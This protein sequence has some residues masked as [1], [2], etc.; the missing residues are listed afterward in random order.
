MPEIT[1]LPAQGCR[2]SRKILDYLEQHAIPFT[3]IDLESDE[4]QALAERYSLRASPGI[5]VDGQAI[6]PFDLLIQPQ[7]RVNQAAAQ[8]VFQGAASG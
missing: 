1:V 7:C 8:A 5:L 4:G 2:R 3:R 6:N